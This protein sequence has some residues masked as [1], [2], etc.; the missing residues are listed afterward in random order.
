MSDDPD[1]LS[2]ELDYIHEVME[3]YGVSVPLFILMFNP[4]MWGQSPGNDTCFTV[5][6]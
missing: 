1:I 4:G 5:H 6:A 2:K 3:R